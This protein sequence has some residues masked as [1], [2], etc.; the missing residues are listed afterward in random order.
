MFWIFLVTLRLAFCL[1]K[2]LSHC[3][4]HLGIQHA[5]GSRRRSC[6]PEEGIQA[7]P[8]LQPGLEDPLRSNLQVCSSLPPLRHASAEVSCAWASI[9]L[10]CSSIA[11]NKAAALSNLNFLFFSLDAFLRPV[12][13]S[14]IQMG[15]SLE[16][17][18]QTKMEKN[19]IF[20]FFPLN[21]HGSRLG[22]G[23]AKGR[24]Q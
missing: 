21:L 7:K 15:P 24:K 19:S 4:H 5:A 9:L 1:A 11:P 14:A 22:I 2:T 16:A 20:F 10:R 3:I 17:C 12:C 13:K 8:V 6:Q 18:E 23:R